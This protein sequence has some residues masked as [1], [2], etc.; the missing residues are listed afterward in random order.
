MYWFYDPTFYIFVVPALIVALVAQINVKSTYSKYSRLAN[1]AGLTGA[2]AARRILDANGLTN[3]RIEHISGQLSDHFDPRSNVVRLSDG[4]FASNSVAAIG[5]AAHEVGHAIQYS[6]SYFP[7]RIRSAIIPITNIGSNLSFP[8]V[9]LGLI[10]SYDPLVT[11]G[12]F[13]YLAV[14]L[15]QLVTLPVEFN[16]SARALRTIEDNGWLFGEEQKG[17]KRVL[18]AAALTYVAALFTALMNLF[19]LIAIAGRRRD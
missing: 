1:S 14:V 4:V 13:L 15:F 3:V 8:L 7:M 17:A 18:T 5:V 12:I 2:E 16:A 6:Q 9:V 11:V 10:F 19:R